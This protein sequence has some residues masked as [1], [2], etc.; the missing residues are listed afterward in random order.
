MPIPKAELQ[1]LQGLSILVETPKGPHS[2]LQQGSPQ[3]L[4]AL[5]Q[6]G[7]WAICPTLFGG[8]SEEKRLHDLEHRLRQAG[9]SSVAVR[10][11]L[12]EEE[13]TG[14]FV[15]GMSR[16]KAVALGY[17]MKLWAVFEVKEATY[18]V[19]YTGHNSR[20]R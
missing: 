6:P 13:H 9:L 10:F 3:G 1:R 16:A 5:I 12:S 11:E 17:K 8:D 19:V 4:P 20:S 14:R 18:S 15:L 2:I 7:G